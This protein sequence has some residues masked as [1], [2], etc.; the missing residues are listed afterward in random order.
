LGRG[1]VYKIK[2]DTKDILIGAFPVQERPAGFENKIFLSGK[3]SQFSFRIK[4]EGGV[5]GE[6][7]AEKEISL[8]IRKLVRKRD[9]IGKRNIDIGLS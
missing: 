5:S 6:D 8:L 2:K 7:L 9:G 3:Q 4:F 1:F